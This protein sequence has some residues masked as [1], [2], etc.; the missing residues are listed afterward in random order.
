MLL[1]P[2]KSSKS[3]FKRVQTAG[4][5]VCYI[6]VHIFRQGT[7]HWLSLIITSAAVFGGGGVGQCWT[8]T[9]LT[10]V[11]EKANESTSSWKDGSPEVDGCSAV[12][13]RDW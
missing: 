2:L 4:C 6:Y 9:I 3:V 8:S 1:S 7:R 11:L 5:Y 12:W 10:T 13:R